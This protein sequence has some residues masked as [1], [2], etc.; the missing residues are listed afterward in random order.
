MSE[1][2]RYLSPA[3]T[4]YPVVGHLVAEAPGRRGYWQPMCRLVISLPGWGLRPVAGLDWRVVDGALIVED[5]YTWDVSGPAINCPAA[6]LASLAHDLVCE[7]TPDG[8]AIASYRQRHRLY[9]RIAR[10]QG[11]SRFRAGYH[12]LSLMAFN[13]IWELFR[14]RK[15]RQ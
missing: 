6:V 13:W 4:L 12:Y 9:Y 7:Q 14:R 1:R 11:M 8:R 2:T 10:R 5:T 15:D 3:E